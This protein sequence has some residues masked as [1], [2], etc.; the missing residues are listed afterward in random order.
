MRGIEVIDVFEIYTLAPYLLYLIQD[1]WISL[2]SIL[3]HSYRSLLGAVMIVAQKWLRSVSVV[4]GL[5]RSDSV[6]EVSQLAT[7]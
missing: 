4:T 6:A 3:V 7:E 5:R 2:C 1:E